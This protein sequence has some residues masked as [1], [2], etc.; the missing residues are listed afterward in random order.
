MTPDALAVCALEHDAPVVFGRARPDCGGVEVACHWAP[1]ERAG[2]AGVGFLAP[3]TA[4]ATAGRRLCR[5]KGSGSHTN[6][7]STE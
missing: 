6:P 1:V 3:R 2:H 5:L 7:L 4:G